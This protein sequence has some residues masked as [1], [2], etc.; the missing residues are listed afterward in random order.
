LGNKSDLPNQFV[1][2]ATGSSP[3]ELPFLSFDHDKILSSDDILNKSDSPS[4][5]S[6]EIVPL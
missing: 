2:I 6:T 3:A 5:Y 4:S 1:L